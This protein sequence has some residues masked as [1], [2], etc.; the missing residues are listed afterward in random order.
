MMQIF[1]DTSAFMAVIDANDQFHTA[2]KTAWQE[3]LSNDSILITS[4]YL[5]LETTALLQH[6]FGMDAVR[7]LESSILP[8]I[9][10][11]WIDQAIHKQ[12]VSALLAANRRELSLVDCTSFE[13]MRLMGLET[14]FTFDPRFREQGFALLPGKA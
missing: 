1:M 4:N 6:R 14:V 10:V 13:I 3:I 12:A 8:A 5:L 11:I 2:A 7:V 9:E